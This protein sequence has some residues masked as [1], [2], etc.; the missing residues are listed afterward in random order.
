ME[1]IFIIILMLCLGT[2]LYLI[3]KAL[4]RIAEVPGDEVDFF[5]RWAH[6]ELPEKVDAAINSFLLKFL[7]KIKVLILKLDNTLGKHVQKI[8][9]EDK[10][11]K[12]SIDFKEISGQN[13]EGSETDPE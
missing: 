1:L 9:A 10:E 13:K 8:K 5:D 3:V 4:P 7:R 2:V 6:S 12:Q 11:K